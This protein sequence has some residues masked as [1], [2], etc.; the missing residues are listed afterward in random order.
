[1]H[2]Q[3]EDGSKRIMNMK[4]IIY[5]AIALLVS[6]A[7]TEKPSQVKPDDPDTPAVTEETLAQKIAGEWHCTVSDY[8]AD[9][10][11]S[12]LS[13][14]T[15]ELYQKVGEG[16]HRLYKGTWAIDETTRVLSGKYN[17][18]AS[19]G[20]SYETTISEDKNSMTLSPKEAASKED[21]VYKRCAIPAEVKKNCVIEVKSDGSAVPV[22]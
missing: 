16:S 18:G 17:D 12:L 1:M 13:D 20:S 5:L 8:D 22:L 2:P 4:K 3:T 21:H 9:I 10:Y 6:A 15:F 11:L 7:C 19:W 14:K